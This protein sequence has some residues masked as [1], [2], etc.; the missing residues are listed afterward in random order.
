MAKRK[1]P[2]I[3]ARD[4]GPWLEWLSEPAKELDGPKVLCR[5]RVPQ[6]VGPDGGD[7][8]FFEGP[9]VIS[10]FCGCGGMDLGVEMAGFT[11]VVQC[12]WDKT[13]CETLMVN[14][15]NC[16]KHAALIQG[17]IRQTPTSILLRE[18]GLRVGEAY[19]VCGGPPCQGFST[20]G[21]REV[22]DIRNTLVFDFLRV[23]REAKP[24]FFVFENVPGFTNL[25]KGQL[26]RDFLAMAHDCYYELV[27]GLVNAV[28]Y[29]VPQN[30][31][32][33]ICMG[34]RRDLVEVEGV[35]ASLPE[36]QCFADRELDELSAVEE[37]PGRLFD[38]T[39]S[40]IRRPPGI[41]YFADRPVL[42]PPAPCPSISSE[43]RGDRFYRWYR[44]LEAKEPDRVVWH[45][46]DLRLNEPVLDR[47]GMTLMEALA[48]VGD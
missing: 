38:S 12:E 40:A 15:P 17:D 5:R 16:F 24:R 18:G 3:L 11:T 14:R 26:M 35:M 37:L 28:E 7:I 31:I 8:A 48:E 13:C 41:R 45:P 46:Q 2:I 19:M 44:D 9:P 1:S 36:P 6:I 32:R 10:L 25:A 43:T 42:V 23:V 27:Y 34:T 39:V 21:K 33:F 20:I 22:G 47:D 4:L 30:R 29:G